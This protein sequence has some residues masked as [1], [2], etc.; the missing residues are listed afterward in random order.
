VQTLLKAHPA[1]KRGRLAIKPLD[2]DA[3]PHLDGTD[4]IQ[5]LLNLV[6]NAFQSSPHSQTVWLV[7]ERVATPL[8]PPV[9][10]PATTE[11]VV[12]LEGFVNTAP[13]LALTVLD[14]GS[15]ISADILPRI[16][17]AYFTTKTKTGTGLGLA[18]V[19]RLVRSHHGLIHLKTRPNEGTSITLYFPLKA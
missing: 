3:L 5:I 8:V 9:N 10:V 6:I 18:I 4:F 19:A 16:F 13:L 17:D 11:R 1:A 15:G 12:G 7:A 14:Q 2:H